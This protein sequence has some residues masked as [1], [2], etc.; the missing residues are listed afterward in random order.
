LPDM[1]I[2]V[3][4]NLNPRNYSKFI[5]CGINDWGGISPVTIDYVNPESPWP[6]IQEVIAITQQAGYVLRA[7]LPIYPEYINEKPGFINENL[8]ENIHVLSGSDGLVREDYL[9]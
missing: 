3:P 8:R 6:K 7:R 9:N 2:Q 5:D 4:P 1:N